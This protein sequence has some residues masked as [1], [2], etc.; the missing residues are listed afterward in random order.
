MIVFEANII[1]ISS[2]KMVIM[3]MVLPS[4]WHH[5]LT[6]KPVCMGAKWYIAWPGIIQQMRVLRDG[7]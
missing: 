3:S 5:G 1:A 7:F 6:A 2:E 4:R